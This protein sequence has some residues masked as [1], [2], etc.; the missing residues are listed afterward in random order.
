M[1]LLITEAPRVDKFE[2]LLPCI[3]K[4]QKYLV[5]GGVD[6][7]K[8]IRDPGSCSPTALPS[9]LKVTRGLMEL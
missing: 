8:D 1:Q 5:Q 9:V 2:N 3:L 7:I 4:V 6:P